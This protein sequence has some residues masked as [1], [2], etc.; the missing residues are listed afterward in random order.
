MA[1]IYTKGSEKTTILEPQE[2]PLRQ[3]GLG[4][5]TEIRIGAFFS[6][7]AATGPNDN[8]VSESL[9]PSL[10]TDYLVFGI[11]NEGQPMPGHTG[12]LFLGI[13]SSDTNLVQAIPSAGFQDSSGTWKAVSY[14]DAT[15]D[16]GGAVLTSV[17][18]GQCNPTGGTGYCSFI[19]IKFVINNRGLSTQT[20]S[21]S[22]A[23]SSNGIAGNDYSATALRTFLNN[24]AYNSPVTL[25]W[26]TGAAARPIPDYFYIRSPLFNNRIRL[27]AVRAIRYA[28]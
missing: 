15:M 2:A 25:D 19:G 26:N 28:P 23:N 27:S 22:A 12:S 11:K 10:I 21:I 5:W 8:A 14:V 1:S 7:I 13:R 3:F 20:V 16:L 24:T 17:A 9:V 6:A 18:I 4:E